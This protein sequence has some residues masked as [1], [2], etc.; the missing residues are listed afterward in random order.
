MAAMNHERSIPLNNQTIDPVC[1]MT[2]KTDAA[3]GSVEFE[4][5]TYF[6]CSRHCVERFRA[7]P[8]LYLTPQPQPLT[9]IGI[10]RERVTPSETGARE[11]TCPMHPQI[12]RNRPGS[13]PICGMALEPRTI[14]TTEEENPELT[15]MTRR[16]WVSVFLTLPVFLIGMNDLL[17][18]RPFERLATMGALGWIQLMLVHSGCALVWLAVFRARVA[19]AHKSQPEHV[20]A[21]WIRRWSFLRLQRYCEDRA[22]RFSGIV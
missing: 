16:F 10:Y 14:T 4:G 20:H 9:Q 6:F 2:V 21:D 5:R 12:V 15:D 8:S 18:G 13:C 19:I 17:P 1:G 11:Y 22:W 7:E 3:A